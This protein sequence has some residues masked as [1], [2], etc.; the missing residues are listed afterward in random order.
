[1]FGIFR[2]AVARYV[3]TPGYRP[4][5][6]PPSPPNAPVTPSILDSWPITLIVHPVERW[7]TDRAPIDYRTAVSMAP[8]PEIDRR[9]LNIGIAE[10]PEPEELVIEGRD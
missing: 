1:M 5:P 9:R 8:R 4:V 6:P 2:R 3:T 10:P 7:R